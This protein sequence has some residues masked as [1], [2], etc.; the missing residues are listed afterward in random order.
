[1]SFA[2]RAL[3]PTA[4]VL[5]F[6]GCAT[7]T[8]GT[9]QNVM[10]QTEPP[11]ADC[12]FSKDGKLIARANPTP[13]SIIVSKGYGGVLVECSKDNYQSTAG[14]IG[15]EFQAMSLGNILLGGIVGVA[16]DAA[17]GAMMKYPESVTFTLVPLYF[18]NANERDAFFNKMRDDFLSEYKEVVARIERMC[19]GP[20]CERQLQAAQA[21]REAKLAEIEEKRL[22]A[23]VTAS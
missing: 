4:A 13:A 10:V 2:L 16:V 20:A 17:S 5:M 22:L 8:T 3:L 1:M 9:T 19:K 15:S 18:P 23:K 21:G 11:G 12:R 7:I 14:E 6:S